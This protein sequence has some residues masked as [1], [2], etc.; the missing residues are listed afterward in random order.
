MIYGTTMRPSRGRYMRAN[1]VTDLI[2]TMSPN[3]RLV[4]WLDVGPLIWHQCFGRP[5][6]TYIGTVA[7]PSIRQHTPTHSH[8]DSM[9]QLHD[10][11]AEVTPLPKAG[12]SPTVFGDFTGD[13]HHLVSGQTWKSRSSIFVINWILLVTLRIGSCPRHLGLN[14][15]MFYARDHLKG[16]FYLGC[17]WLMDHMAKVSPI[18]PMPRMHVLL[19]ACI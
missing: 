16:G 11:E 10:T 4:T 1:W 12:R 2:R 15:G 8:A 14:M 5:W 9:A 3:P 17:M 18:P 6:I 19:D 13:N 7:I